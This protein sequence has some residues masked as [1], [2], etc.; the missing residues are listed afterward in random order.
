MKFIKGGTFVARGRN[1]FG[2]TSSS[3]GSSNQR[4][5]ASSRGGTWFPSADTVLWGLIGAN[6]VVFTLWRIADPSFMI[7]NFTVS[8]DNLKSGRVHTL[9][10][11]AFGQIN[12]LHFCSNVI[13]LFVFG[14]TIGK[15]FGP[16]FLLKL[17]FAGAICG[18]VIFLVHHAFMDNPSGKGAYGLG[19]SGAVDAIMLLYIFLFPKSTLY[20]YLVIP[21]PAMLVGAFFI[22]GDLYRMKKADGRITGGAPFGGAVVATVAWLGI[23][24][25][26]WI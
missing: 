17:Y 11:S 1:L 20:L 23:M 6:A 15:L 13:G 5:S 2:S 19:A 16:Q 8:L 18:S 3:V 12:N 9:I 7:E 22:A 10:T 4:Y 24:R 14:N 25:G 21:V 26:W